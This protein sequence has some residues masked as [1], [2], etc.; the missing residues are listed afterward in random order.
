MQQIERGIFYEDSFLGVTLGGLVYSHGTILI[1][2]PLRT[3]DARSWRA[4]LL[5]QRGGAN[6]LLINLD[7]HPDRTLGDRA[8][9]CIIVTHEQ[10]AQRLRDQPT[11]FKGQNIESGAAWESYGDA[12]GMRWA[13]PD[14]TFTDRMSL[15]WGGPE[16]LLEHHP[17]SAPG[18]IWVLIPEEKV[19]YVGDAVVLNQPPFL[20]NA[21]LSAW[22]EVLD[23]LQSDFRGY[24]IVSGR[25]GLA[26][27]D[28]VRAQ[29]NF[30]QKVEKG[31]ERLSNKNASA[32]A[33]E[34]LASSLLSGIEV[35]KDLEEEYLQRLQYGLFHYYNRHYRQSAFNEISLEEEEEQ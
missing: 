29:K 14:I 8:L 35:P 19:V 26:A 25:G 7:Q 10:T 28:D 33:T 12:I 30:L 4:T 24:T 11:I 23:L 15:Y 6:R 13:N 18:A 17:G 32:E 34:G 16:I 27:V 31:L 9:D 22:L 20:A 1:D 2:A 21:D 5:N 3:E